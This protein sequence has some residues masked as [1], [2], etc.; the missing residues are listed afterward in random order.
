[1]KETVFR[2]ELKF[3]SDQEGVLQ[4]LNDK[5]RPLKGVQSIEEESTDSGFELLVRVCFEDS[6]SATKLHARL[7]ARSL[8]TMA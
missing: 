1:M 2:F 5:L 7:P 3:A 6:E 4:R 8:A